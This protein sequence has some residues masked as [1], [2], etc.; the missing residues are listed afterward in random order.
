QV[1][2][3]GRKL[4]GHDETVKMASKKQGTS[5]SAGSPIALVSAAGSVQVQQDLISGFMRPRIDF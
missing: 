1:P 5:E 4:S 2:I 3:D